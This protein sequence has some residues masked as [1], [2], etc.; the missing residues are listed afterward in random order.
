MS[1]ILYGILI[2]YTTLCRLWGRLVCLSY[3]ELLLKHPNA[4]FLQLNAQKTT[5][6]IY[7]KIL[8]ITKL[9]ED[10]TKCFKIFV[11]T[12]RLKAIKLIIY[13]NRH[14]RQ[15]P[16][17]LCNVNQDHFLHTKE[18]RGNNTRSFPCTLIC[19]VDRFIIQLRI[20]S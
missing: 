1:S 9:F 5:H 20:T 4:R 15:H 14:D 2:S 11:Q 17:P 6:H 10:K 7:S 13:K 3:V 12:L 18:A 8:N 19:K 16:P